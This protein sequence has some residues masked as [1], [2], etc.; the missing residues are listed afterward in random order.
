MKVIRFADVKATPWINGGGSVNVIAAGALGH[1]GDPRLEPGN[2]WDWRLSLA[3][4]EQPGE[5][6]RLPG[7]ERI[8]T[9]VDG[10]P[11]QLT[12][13]GSHHLVPALRPFAFDGGAVTTAVLPSGPVRNLNLMCRAGQIEGN[14]TIAPVHGSLLQPQ[15][16]AVLL[17]GQASVGAVALRRFDTVFTSGTSP[18]LMRGKGT[19]ALVE[20]RPRSEP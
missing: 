11:L 20:I 16:A 3:S 5:F 6:S 2:Q 17:A 18:V 12:I 13:G 7:I 19:L 1:N 10:G 4:V 8:L 9:V 14:V 15:Q